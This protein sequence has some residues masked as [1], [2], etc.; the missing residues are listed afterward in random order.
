[1]RVLITSTG[2]QGHV[3][4]LLP[5]ARELAARGDEVAWA[6]P[7]E[8]HGTIAAAGIRAVPAGEGATTCLRAF[9]ARWPEAG[10]MP[11]EDAA[12]FMFPRLFGDVAAPRAAPG[13]REAVEAVRPRYLLHEVC[14]A[15]A[16]LVAREAGIPAVAHGVGLGIRSVLVE[17]LHERAAAA[18]G[19]RPAGA[20]EAPFVDLCPPSLRTPEVAW[21][22]P[23]LACR[24]AGVEDGQEAIELP[25]GRPRVLVT[26]GTV[27]GDPVALGRAA[28][29]VAA[30]GAT[31]VVTEP[32]EH[33]GAGIVHRPGT[34]HARVLPRCA[35]VVCHGGAGIVLRALATGV[36]LVCLPQGPSDQHR[37]AAVV[38]RAG[39]GLAPGASD[40]LE[41]AVVRLLAEP[42]FGAA[43][44]RLA[45][46]IAAMPS[47]ASVAGRLADIARVRSAIA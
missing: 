40:G 16:P 22:G 15:A 41:E 26:F 23:E 9:A 31:A 43:A 42:G 24:P 13:V 20:R 25:A 4:P 39:A 35:A 11:A 27:A 33:V 32:L 38:A 45:G 3:Q 47:P 14:E 5:L 1:M 28:R 21:P 6:A 7:P 44:R 8:A 37:N 34:P 30:A 29:A 2:G 18:L 36:P 10:A 12:P 17:A 46:E 19:A